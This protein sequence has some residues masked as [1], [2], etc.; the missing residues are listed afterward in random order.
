MKLLAAAIA[1]GALGCVGLAPGVAHAQEPP[2]TGLLGLDQ[3]LPVDVLLGLSPL[4]G[5][6][7]GAGGGYG[8]TSGGGYG[9]VSGGGYGGVGGVGGVSG[10]GTGGVGGVL[11]GGTGGVSGVGTGGVGVLGGPS[12]AG[13]TARAAATGSLARTGAAST[14][15]TAYGVLLL[16]GGGT[17]LYVTRPRRRPSPQRRATAV[18]RAHHRPSPVRRAGIR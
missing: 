12:A 13:G 2:V 3:V 14:A 16:A 9:G 17:I 15:I 18:R 1:A 11:G 5:D 8:G 6:E 7:P 4:A 10:G